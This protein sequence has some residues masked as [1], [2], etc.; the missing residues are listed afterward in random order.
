MERIIVGCI[1]WIVTIPLL[2]ATLIFQFLELKKDCKKRWD[3]TI[4]VL[5]GFAILS[6]LMSKYLLM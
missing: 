5:Q 6:L 1:D 3:K 2:M 4:I